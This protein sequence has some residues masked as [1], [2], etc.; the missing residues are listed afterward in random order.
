V[1]KTYAG[2]L[3]TCA[4]TGMPGLSG[5]PIY[6]PDQGLVIGV[7]SSSARSPQLTHGFHTG[8]ISEIPSA[9]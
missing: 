6:A 9:E 4:L 3:I 7:Y 1:L 5:A 2:E 8:H